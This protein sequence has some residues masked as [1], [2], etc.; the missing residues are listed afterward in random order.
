[1]SHPLASLR[2]V[3]D[4]EP[5]T[6]SAGDPPT[7]GDPVETELL[8]GMRRVLDARPSFSPSESAAQ[9]VL[10]EA[11][12]AS[13][14]AQP[15]YAAYASTSPLTG[16]AEVLRQSRT[17]LDRAIASHPPPRPSSDVEALIL[18]RAAEASSVARDAAPD[19]IE[20]APIAA[21]YGLATSTGVEAALLASTRDALDRLPTRQPD[22]SALDAVRAEAAFVATTRDALDRLPTHQPDASTL[23]AILAQAAL[24]SAPHEASPAQTTAPD[25]AAA[26]PSDRRRRMG[27]IWIGSAALMAVVLIGVFAFPFGETGVDTESALADAAPVAAQSE[28]APSDADAGAVE[29]AEEVTPNASA[30]FAAAS[31]ARVVQRSAPRGPSASELTPVRAERGATNDFTASSLPSVPSEADAASFEEAVPASATQAGEGGAVPQW[32]VSDDVRLLSL[33]LQE[34][35]RQNEGLAWDEPAE[36]FGAPVATESVQPGIQAVREGAAPARAQ[37]R[38]RSD[39]ARSNQ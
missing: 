36:A 18:A 21:A 9:A 17:L 22:A 27:G 20:L 35:R 38:V 34:L 29:L 15:L 39:S 11:I 25:R 19:A 33:R 37:V 32:D 16:E 24:A 14:T 7:A 3:Y 5:P 30:P 13:S 2:H 4:V 10:D 8:R 28:P 12:A 1:M 6:G 31:P 23:E 26:A